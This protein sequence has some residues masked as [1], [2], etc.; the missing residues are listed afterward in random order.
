[1]TG[2]VLVDVIEPCLEIV[3]KADLVGSLEADDEVEVEVVELIPSLVLTDGAG[4]VVRVMSPVTVAVVPVAGVEPD[5][6][7]WIPLTGDADTAGGIDPLPPPPPFPLSIT[8]DPLPPV[9]IPRFRAVVASPPNALVDVDD[10]R[11]S[12]GRADVTVDNDD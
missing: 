7:L 5:L 4:R 11:T 12:R 6:S 2:S 3:G 8:L 1:M 10:G 9:P